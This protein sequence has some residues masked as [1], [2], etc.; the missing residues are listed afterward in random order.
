MDSQAGQPWKRHLTRLEQSHTFAFA[1][2][3]LYCQ[4]QPK[5]IHLLS[6]SSEYSLSSRFLTQDGIVTLY[7]GGHSMAG[8]KDGFVIL[9]SPLVQAVAAG[10]AV[11][12]LEPDQNENTSAGN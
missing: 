8:I 3:E 1:A 12:H 2:Q 10:F 6:V 9:F 11:P 5:Y 4:T 7:L